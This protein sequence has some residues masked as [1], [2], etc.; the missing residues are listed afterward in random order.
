[1]IKSR[2]LLILI[3]ASLAFA[4][5]DERWFIGNSGGVAVSKETNS[6]LLKTA[7]QGGKVDGDSCSKCP[8]FQGSHPDQGPW[9]I[10]S[11]VMGHF[12]SAS[13]EEALI[14]SNLCSVE[15]PGFQTRLG[16]WMLLGKRNGKWTKLE[17]DTLAPDNCVQKK[18][19]SGR[20]FLICE[21]WQYQRDGEV[22]YRLGTVMLENNSFKGRELLAATDSTAACREG[23]NA[24]K[25]VVQDIAFR[26]LNGDGLE[27]ISITATYG[28]FP[29]T[30]RRLEQCT[31]AFED[32]VQTTGKG[33]KEYPQPKVIKT[34]KIQ[35]LFDGNRYTL[36]PESRAGAALFRELR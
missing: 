8:D 9:K 19:S 18:L 6:A 16:F 30:G 32:R 36:T 13:S 23:N 24:E 35:Y 26:D 17:D 25:G 1:M 34:Y 12:S 22:T 3:S 27:D 33:V 15:G 31:A 5:D 28:S 29:M 4:L 11:V 7:C 2:I 10:I 21:S 20:E 14:R